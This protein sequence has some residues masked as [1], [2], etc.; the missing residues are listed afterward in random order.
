MEILT[1]ILDWILKLI[2]VIG[3]AGVGI[4]ALIYSIRRK[5]NGGTIHQKLD[6][7]V[8]KLQVLENRIKNI[9]KNQR[10]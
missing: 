8:K 2:P 10:K 5:K 4:G 7:L 1:E 3:G 6:A 9:E